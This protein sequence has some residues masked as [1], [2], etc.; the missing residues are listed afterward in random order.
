[1]KTYLSRL[2]LGMGVLML[3]AGGAWGDDGPMFRRNIS[4]TPADDTEFVS[5]RMLPLYV[6]AQSSDG[7]LLTDGIDYLTAD[8]TVAETRDYARPLIA[9]YQDG[10]VEFIEEYE[11]FPGHGA[12]DSYA[13]VSLDD[14]ATWKRTNL[15]NSAD[16]SSITLKDGRQKVRYPGDTLRNFLASDGN[17]ALFVWVSKYCDSGSPTYAMSDTEKEAVSTYLGTTGCTDGD[18]ATPCLY[19]DDLFGVA[20]QQGVQSAEDLAEEGYPLVGDYPYSCLWVARGVLL[21]PAA[22]GEQSTFV[23]YKA[24]RLTSGVRSAERAEV[25]CVKGAGC[26]VT[27]QEDPE[28]VRPGHG[29]GPG[30]GWSGAIAHH[31]TDTW[32]SYIDW[33]DFDLVSADGTY[34]TFYNTTGSLAEWVVANPT[35]SPQA[36]VP[37]SIPVRATDNAM[38]A[39]ADGNLDTL[40]DDPYCYMDFNGNGT[41]D[42]C[43]STVA[44]TIETPEGP[45]QTVNMCVSEDGRLM[46]VSYTHLTLPTKR[47]V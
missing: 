15:S 3:L 42:F 40:E 43:A 17:K 21:P 32:Y 1:M 13:A 20:G 4:N 11:A 28:G 27:W 8:G 25:V 44:V 14:G 39:D 22:E 45:T 36:A 35:G 6:P 26:T 47:I 5:L 19:L 34:G 7:T 12:R 10:P 9:T 24:E 18:A 2:L 29:D 33:D 38:C 46:P 41:P 30:E 16:R 23:W 31:Q 37:M